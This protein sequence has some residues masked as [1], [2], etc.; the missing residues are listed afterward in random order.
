MRDWGILK[1]IKNNSILREEVCDCL[2]KMN[3]DPNFFIERRKRKEAESLAEQKRIAREMRR[4]KKNY[5]VFDDK[6]FDPEECTKCKRRFPRTKQYWHRGNSF[7]GLRRR[8]K[9]CQNEHTKNYKKQKREG[10]CSNV[11]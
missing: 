4:R 8:C 1:V 11:H 9:Y 7:D 2:H 10:I 6:V 5:V 3:T